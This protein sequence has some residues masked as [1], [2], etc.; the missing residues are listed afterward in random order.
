MSEAQTAWRI[1]INRT[2]RQATENMKRKKY[3]KDCGLSQHL[4]R[5]VFATVHKAFSNTLTTFSTF[6]SF[7]G[8]G[9][10]VLMN[11]FNVF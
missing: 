11:G 5:K 10:N 6:V 3:L 2:S 1:S 9:E 8:G 4:N 7:V